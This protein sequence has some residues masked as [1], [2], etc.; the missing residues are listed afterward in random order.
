[1]TVRAD[2]VEVEHR[3]PGLDVTWVG[4][5]GFLVIA[6]LAAAAGVVS[7]AGAAD[8]VA[9]AVAVNAVMLAVPATWLWAIVDDWKRY[10][11]VYVGEEGLTRITRSG[12]RRVIPLDDIGTVHRHTT[13]PR[14]VN[15][16]IWMRRIGQRFGQRSDSAGRSFVVVE[17]VSG[18]WPWVF[19]TNEWQLGEMFWTAFGTEPGVAERAARGI[20]DIEDR[21]RKIRRIGIGDQSRSL[22]RWLLGSVLWVL[23]YGEIVGWLRI[24]DYDTWLG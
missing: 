5:V 13:D 8:N 20:H 15:L 16:P 22:F 17:R 14:R 10:G 6:I 4:R 12:R 18:K 3:W 11:R 23:L 1:M 7:I 21:Y 24:I 19:D 9:T 2:G